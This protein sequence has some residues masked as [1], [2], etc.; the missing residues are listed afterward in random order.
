MSIMNV[1]VWVNKY[2]RRVQVLQ[3][4]SNGVLKPDVFIA[5]ALL[6]I[7]KFVILA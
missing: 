6:P 5:I 7:S 2:L 1:I 4:I 3:K